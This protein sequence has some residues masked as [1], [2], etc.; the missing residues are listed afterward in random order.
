MSFILGVT[1]KGVFV[2]IVIFVVRLMRQIC[3]TKRLMRRYSNRVRLLFLFWFTS[4]AVTHLKG[5]ANGGESLCDENLTRAHLLH[6][7]VS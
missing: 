1:D 3:L 6:M 5:V 4:A 7:H 2:L